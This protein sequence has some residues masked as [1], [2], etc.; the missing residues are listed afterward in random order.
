MSW[1][2][3]VDGG[4]TKTLAAVAGADG[5]TR[6]IG[7]AGC[8]DI[9]NAATPERGIDEMEAAARQALAAA[10][11]GA[12]AIGAAAFSLAGADWPEDFALLEPALRDRLGLRRAA[13]R[14]Q[15]RARRAAHGLARLDRDRGRQ[16]H[17]QRGRRAQRPTARCSTSASG[18]TARAGATSGAPA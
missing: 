4:N 9:Y 12:E 1:V 6:G 7:R 5:V 18:P 16:R 3:G 8:S 13:A 10:G 11:V 14:R 15:R 2:L 17:L